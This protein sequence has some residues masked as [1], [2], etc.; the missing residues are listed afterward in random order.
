MFYLDNIRDETRLQF[1]RDAVNESYAMYGGS[2]RQ[3]APKLTEPPSG[4]EEKQETAAPPSG[5]GMN[6]YA[7]AACGDDGVR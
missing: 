7:A 5:D 3:S 1:L 2:R 6:D 4:I